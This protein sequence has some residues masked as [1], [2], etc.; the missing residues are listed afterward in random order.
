[1]HA[2]YFRPAEE[3]EQSGGKTPGEAIPGV[4]SADA[5]EV[6]EI[7]RTTGHAVYEPQ[8]IPFFCI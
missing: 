1:M 4:F 7:D 8:K 3:R 2:Q 6:W 5:D